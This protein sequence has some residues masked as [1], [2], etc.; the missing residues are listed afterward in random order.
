MAVTCRLMFTLALV[1]EVELVAVVL[2][3]VTIVVVAESRDHCR[4]IRK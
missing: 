2:V 4:Y 1:V 3:A